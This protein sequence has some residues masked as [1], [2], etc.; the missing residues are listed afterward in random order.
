MSLLNAW[1]Q[2]AYAAGYFY[3]RAKRGWTVDGTDAPTAPAPPST[4]VTRRDAGNRMTRDEGRGT[5]DGG[6]SDA[7]R[8]PGSRE[9]MADG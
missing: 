9:P 8:E 1:S 3:E 4:V 7:N 2:V 5:G 6:N